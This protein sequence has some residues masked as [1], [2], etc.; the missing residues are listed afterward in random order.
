MQ[1]N[2]REDE[3]SLGRATIG[4]EAERE[5]AQHPARD[6]DEDGGLVAKLAEENRQEQKTNDIGHLRER[7]LHQHAFPLQLCEIHA[8]VYKVEIEGDADQKHARDEDRERRFLEQREGVEPEDLREAHVG[9]GLL[10]R[11][12]RQHQ[13]VEAEHDRGAARDEELRGRLRARDQLQAE[14][15]GD[16]ADGGEH[17]HAREIHL[18]VGEV[19]ERKRVPQCEGR[20]IERA[21]ENQHRVERRERRAL[22]EQAQDDATENAQHRE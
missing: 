22:R 12:V 8:E 4:T 15:S 17:L 16:P 13:R 20:H 14:E 18:G 21:V 1:Q 3:R 11:R 19:G 5:I 10:G 2:R 7:G 6:P 9:T